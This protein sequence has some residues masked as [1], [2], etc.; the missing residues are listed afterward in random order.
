MTPYEQQ[1]SEYLQQFLTPQRRAK[2][3]EVLANRTRKLTVV[4]FD[5]FQEHNASAI[6]RTCEA[7]GIQDVHIV[8]SENRFRPKRDIAMGTE[9]WLTLHRYQGTD[10]LQ[11]C[12]RHLQSRGFRIAA[13]VLD[14]RSQCV[15]DLTVSA[16]HPLALVFGTEKHGLPQMAIEM[17]DLLVKVPMF[18]FVESFNVSVATALSLQALTQRLRSGNDWELT[19][20]EQADLLLDW[21]RKTV[22]NCEAI[23]LRFRQDCESSSSRQTD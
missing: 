19:D 1:L 17:A 12:L 23:E 6:L 14:D 16:E 21:T 10:S 4:V 11:S 5:L 2:F 20:Q 9:R 7:F 13:T 8:E 15:T 3:A 22:P 18:G